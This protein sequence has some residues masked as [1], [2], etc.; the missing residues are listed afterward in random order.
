MPNH[1]YLAWRLI[2]SAAIAKLFTFGTSNLPASKEGGEGDC[3]R[4]NQM[5]AYEQKV[6]SLRHLPFIQPCLVPA[7]RVREILTDPFLI[8]RRE[9]VTWNSPP[10]CWLGLQS[11]LIFR[12]RQSTSGP[13]NVSVFCDCPTD[14]PIFAVTNRVESYMNGNK[15]WHAIYYIKKACGQ[16]RY[17]LALSRRGGFESRPLR[18]LWQA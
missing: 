18:Y 5:D 9:K 4:A 15:S 6:V 17:F 8:R 3:S 1:R 7:N 13:Y 14:C 16:N 10:S 12:R 2:S 11:L